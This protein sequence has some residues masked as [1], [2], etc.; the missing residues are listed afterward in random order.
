MILS[1]A[2][3][4]TYAALG[5]LRTSLLSDVFQAI[6]AVIFLI[7]VLAIVGERANDLE[8]LC[9]AANRTDC[10]LGQWNPVRGRTRISLEVI[11]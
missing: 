4:L 11:L 7:V 1:T 6:L 9:N 5:G 8:P 2:V 3:P 10:T